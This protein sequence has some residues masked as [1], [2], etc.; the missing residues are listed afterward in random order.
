MGI[1]ADGRAISPEKSTGRD[2][3]FGMVVGFHG[4][5]AQQAEGEIV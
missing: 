1:W 4:G 5:E 3:D 2:V